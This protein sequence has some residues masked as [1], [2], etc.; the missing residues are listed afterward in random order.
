[1]IITVANEKGGVAKTTVAIHLATWLAREGHRVVL[2]DADTQGSIGHFLDLPPADDLAEL[3][4]AVMYLRPDRRPGITSFLHQAPNHPR[5]V[6]LR[7]H[8]AT[9]QVAAEMVTTPGLPEPGQVLTQALGALI[10]NHVHIV[11]DTG[12]H[13]DSVQAAALAAADHV[14]IPGIPEGATEAGVL[15]IARRLAAMRK[16]ITAVIP[17][18]IITTSKMH[19]STIAD[20]RATDG[21][22][23]VVYYDPPRGLRGLPRRVVWGELYSHAA[24]IW[25]V[26]PGGKAASEM[27]AVIR[28]LVRDCRIG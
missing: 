3:L 5:L 16:P 1:M 25:D 20:W 17:T 26:E 28:R 8:H 12:P 4:R 27:D 2:V 9:D 24:T 23:A 21:L 11:V 22:G 13:A 7:G 14:V 10:H 19:A 6:V 15:D 18:K